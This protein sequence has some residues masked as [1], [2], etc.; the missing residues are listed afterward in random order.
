[1]DRLSRRSAGK[2]SKKG[3]T[4]SRRSRSATQKPSGS[5]K[6]RS[7]RSRKST[8]NY[9]KLRDDEDEIEMVDL[10]AM[11]FGVSTTERIGATS[12]PRPHDIYEGT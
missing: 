6:G 12:Q 3:G 5:K 8:A 1:M 10:N 2:S 11:N 9:S 7:A 4:S